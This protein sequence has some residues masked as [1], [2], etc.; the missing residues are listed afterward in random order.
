M[1]RI[2]QWVHSRGGA[3]HCLARVFLDTPAGAPIVV[4]SEI[5]SN[6][7]ECGLVGDFAGAANA[8]IDSLRGMIRLAPA[9]LVW[10]AH[11]GA[12]SYFENVGDETFMRVDIKWDGERFYGSYEEQHPLSDAEVARLLG[13]VELKPVPAALAELGWKF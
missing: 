1:S 11:H 5:R 12:F 10:L 3:A 13:E 6:P 8:L 7:D 2:L 4:L 9:Q